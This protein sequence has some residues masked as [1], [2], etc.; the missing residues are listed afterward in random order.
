MMALRR[1]QFEAPAAALAEP[2]P[3]FLTG[4]FDDRGRY[5][6]RA[7]LEANEG[8]IVDA[9]LRE[10]RDALFH[11]HR[12]RATGPDAL[13]EVARRSLAVVPSIARR[14]A[15]NA[16]FHMPFGSPAFWHMGPRSPSDS[17]ASCC[18][19]PRAASWESG[20]AAL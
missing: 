17:D 3:C 19:T 7:L 11:E 18:A 1:Y 2:D 13:L 9:A 5:R 8:A 15:F 12:E 20:T 14:E 4:W 10:A 6:L 16:I